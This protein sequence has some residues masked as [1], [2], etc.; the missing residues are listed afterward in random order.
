MEYKNA[1]R[2]VLTISLLSSNRKDTIRKCLDSLNTLRERVES[3][4]IIVDTGNNE[5][6]KKIHEEYTDLIIPFT[7]CNDFSKARNVGLNAAKGEWFLYLDDDEW[8]IDT[9]D[10]EEFFLSGEY[11]EYGLAYYIQRNYGDYEGM[12]HSDA[13]VSRLF[14]IRDKIQFVSTIHEYPVPLRGKTKLLHSVV[15]HFGYVFDTPEKQYAHSKRNL[16][17]L[18]DM[19]KKERKNARWWLQLIQEYRSINQYPEMQKVCEEA[20]EVFK[21]QNTFEA[22]IARGTLYNAILVKH[23]KFYEYTEAEALFKKAIQDKRNTQMC[24]AALYLSGA[25]IYFNKKDYKLSEKYCKNYLDIYDELHDKD[26]AIFSQGYFFVDEAFHLDVREQLY[27]IYII[28]GLKRDDTENLD[29]YFW[30][31][32]W[33]RAFMYLETSFVEEM[34]DAMGRFPYREEYVKMAA[35]MMDRNGV[36]DAVIKYIQKKEKND[37]EA[38]E[39]LRKI[40]LQMTGRQAYILYLRLTDIDDTDKLNSLLAE[41]TFYQW[42]RT[43]DFICE[44][45]SR[46]RLDRWKELLTDSDDKFGACYDYFLLKDAEVVLMRE[47]KYDYAG[48]KKDIQDYCIKNAAFYRRFFKDN[49]FE[50]EMEMLPVQGR[51]AV[52]LQAVL[53]AEKEGDVK[54]ISAALKNSMNV[55]PPLNDIVVA[56]TSHYAGQQKK[57]LEDEA[58]EQ[59]IESEVIS[60]QMKQLGTQIKKKIEVLLEQNLVAEAQQALTQLKQFLPDDK[61]LDALEKEIKNRL[62]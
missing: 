60:M 56:Y 20:M 15:E 57:R 35:A 53:E 17:L 30:E 61:D 9:E 7:W 42:K 18:L 2:P 16:P 40:F 24:Q 25:N 41:I 34:I 39:N 26:E 1:E 48:L 51:I 8:F 13:R 59:K 14:P 27:S 33:N 49:A 11:R 12:H 29:H 38:F 52:K 22:N 4:L 19:I 3:E 32:G 37:K 10:I 54:D 47:N 21:A 58:Q 43:T 50:G 23:L 28:C 5:E 36:D 31:L 62:S 55:Y 46:E 45:A 44:Y 6:M